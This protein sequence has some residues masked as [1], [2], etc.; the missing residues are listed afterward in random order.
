M[1]TA[2]MEEWLECFDRR[3]DGREGAAAAQITFLP[4]NVL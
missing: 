3:I 2:I 4:V 1:N